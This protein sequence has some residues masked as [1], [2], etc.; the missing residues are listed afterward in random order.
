V[1]CAPSVL[2][3]PELRAAVSDFLSEPGAGEDA[4]NELIQRSIDGFMPRFAYSDVG[5]GQVT[6]WLAEHGL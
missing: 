6:Q 1:R 4:L 3:D 5:S 2:H